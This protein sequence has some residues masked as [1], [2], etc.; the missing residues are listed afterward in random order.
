MALI[1]TL[2]DSDRFVRELHHC[3]KNNF[4]IIASLVNLQKRALPPDRQGE[5]RFV[6]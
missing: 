5:V 6:E 1:Y 2:T 4:Q 3:V